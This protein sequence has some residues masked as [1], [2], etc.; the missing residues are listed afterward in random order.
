MDGIFSLYK[1]TQLQKRVTDLVKYCQDEIVRNIKL[2]QEVAMFLICGAAKVT[3]LRGV[4]WNM[5]T[6]L[7]M[8]L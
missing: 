8:L 4:N 6:M 7:R 1:D 3:S 5:S 2:K